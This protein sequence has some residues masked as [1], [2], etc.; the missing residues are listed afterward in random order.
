MPNVLVAGGYRAQLASNRRPV[1]CT[2][3]STQSARKHCGAQ[4]KVTV[5]TD[6][7]LGCM[8]PIESQAIEV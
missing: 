1:T 8:V 2:L 4:H 5:V 6:T 7:R 3:G